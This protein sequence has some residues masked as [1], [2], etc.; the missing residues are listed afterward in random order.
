MLNS[1]WKRSGAKQMLET[2]GYR[3]QLEFE[4]KPALSYYPYDMSP[5]SSKDKLSLIEY[6]NSSRGCMYVHAREKDCY[7]EQ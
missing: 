5:H 2:V 1:V 4:S 6:L 3:T 7:H